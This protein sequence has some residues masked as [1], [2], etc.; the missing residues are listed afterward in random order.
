MA[1]RRACSNGLG[2]FSDGL[3]VPDPHALWPGLVVYAAATA[4]VPGV[5]AAAQVVCAVRFKLAR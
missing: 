5:S 3:R 4:K 2:P 1:A